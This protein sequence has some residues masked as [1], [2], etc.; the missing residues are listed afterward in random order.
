MFFKKT[1]LKHRIFLCEGSYDKKK[2][3]PAACTEA[4][5]PPEEMPSWCGLWQNVTEAKG[6]GPGHASE[7]AAPL[8]A[9]RLTESYR[10]NV[11]QEA[12]IMCNKALVGL[13]L[14]ATPHRL[15][16][17]NRIQLNT[18]GKQNCLTFSHIQK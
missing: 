5:S 6:P 17:R 3:L 16:L 15:Q 10:N 4:K 12:T 8:T 9:T 13:V 14:L 18:C 11:P 7:G 2:Y 1:R